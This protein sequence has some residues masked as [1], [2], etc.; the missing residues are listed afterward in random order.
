MPA[1]FSLVSVITMENICV[2]HLKLKIKSA[3]FIYFDPTSYAQWTQCKSCN[4][5]ICWNHVIH[6]IVQSTDFGAH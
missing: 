1:E 5:D 6:T 2:S 3:R 4:R